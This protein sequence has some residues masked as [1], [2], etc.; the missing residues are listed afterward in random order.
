MKRVYILAHQEARIRAMRAV[1]DAPI[2]FAVTV[3]EPTRSLEQNAPL[4]ALLEEIAEQVIWHGKKLTKE[5]WKDIFTASI[6]KSQVAPGLDGG[7]V[8][9]GQSTSNMSKSEFS[10]LLELIHCFAAEHEVKLN[11]DITTGRYEER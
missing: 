8:V 11:D 6:R 2:G 1:H 3:S 10:E 5:N 4:W 7:F 9:L